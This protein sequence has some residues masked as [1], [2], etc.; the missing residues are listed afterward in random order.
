MGDFYLKALI[1]AAH[2]SR[3]EEFRA[4]V[5]HLVKQISETRNLAFEIT[6]AAFLQFCD[7]LLESQ[8]DCVVEK[9]ATLITIFPFFISAGSHIQKD[10]PD[11]I[12]TVQ[13]KYPSVQFKLTR[14]LG[15]IEKIKDVIIDEVSKAILGGVSK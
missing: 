14:H 10:I 13:K 12:K 4:E 15:K 8:I 11:L 7:P 9:G 2:G 1:I 5:L 6:E 3:K